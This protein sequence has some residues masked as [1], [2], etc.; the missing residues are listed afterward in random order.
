M[1]RRL[2]IKEQEALEQLKAI[3]DFP[4]FYVCK[5]YYNTKY[6][7]D[8]DEKALNRMSLRFQET[9]VDYIVSAKKKINKVEDFDEYAFISFLKS[10]VYAF[11]WNATYEALDKENSCGI[12]LGYI[13]D[14]KGLSYQELKKL[15][16][17]KD[18]FYSSQLYKLFVR[19]FNGKDKNN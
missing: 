3:T 11:F 6:G 13:N 16:V 1:K 2:T 10:V 17:V 4:K 12:I 7:E 5:T 15:E 8:V 18:W 19:Y 14:K 9:L